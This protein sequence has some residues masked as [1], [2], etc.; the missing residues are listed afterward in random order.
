MEG[1]A[2]VFLRKLITQAGAYDLVITEFVRVTDQKLPNRVFLR[3][4]PELNNDSF[5]DSGTPVRV[6]LLGNHPQ[7]LALNALAAC[8]LGSKGIDLNFGCPSKTV[9]KSQGGAILL[10]EPETIFQAVKAVRE[11]LPDNQIVSAKMRLGYEDTSLMWDCAQAIAAAGANELIV[12]ARTK[13]QGYKP[14]AYWSYVHDF[15]KKLSI[16][17]VINGE[18]WSV[19]DAIQAMKESNTNAVMLGRGAV[20]NPFLA[21]QIK[22]NPS[23]MIET[24]N[25]KLIK[26]YVKS[27]WQIV[28]KEM[29]DR[30]CAG[31]LKQWLKHLAQQYPEA[32][33]LYYSI[34]SE[35]DTDSITD[36][37]TGL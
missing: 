21:S 12:H 3:Q 18:I 10:R 22:T 8:Q 13:Q 6:Q 34:R 5:T 2:D 1:L 4:I 11:A 16:P 37:I 27:F 36:I 15:E 33:E 31:R 17:V 29:S 35:K 9:N 32:E 30:Y 20:Q 25:W 23:E 19:G 26:P 14:P 7:A 28:R 24:V